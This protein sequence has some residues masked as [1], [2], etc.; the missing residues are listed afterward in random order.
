MLVVISKCNFQTDHI[1][2]LE[3]SRADTNLVTQLK[4]RFGFLTLVLVEHQ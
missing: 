2:P 1:L 3:P 4:V